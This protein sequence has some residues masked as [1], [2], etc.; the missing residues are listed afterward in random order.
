MRFRFE[1]VEGYSA[2]PS[3]ARGYVE[4]S[5][6]FGGASSLRSEQPLAPL[7]EAG[8]AND[9]QPLSF[10]VFTTR[11]D[12]IFGAS[13]AAVAAEHPIALAGADRDAGAAAFVEECRRTGTAAAEIETAEKRGYDTGLRVRHPMR[14]GVTHRRSASSVPCSA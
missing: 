4:R 11:P 5:E 13:F 10:E 8:E 7:G 12:T 14:P 2:S 3:G 6:T 1:V 9:T